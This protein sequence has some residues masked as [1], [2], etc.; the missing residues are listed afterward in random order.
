M[1]FLFSVGQWSV[2]HSHWG[3]NFW[4][5]KAG[6]PRGRQGP[7][8]ETNDPRRL[9]DQNVSLSGAL[10]SPDNLLQASPLALDLSFYMLAGHL[11]PTCQPAGLYSLPLFPDPGGEDGEQPRDR[12][13][14][15]SLVH[16]QPQFLLEL[17][18]RC[19]STCP[20]ACAHLG[21]PGTTYHLCLHA[22][23]AK[24]CIYILKW[25][26]TKEEYF[27]TYKWLN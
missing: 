12:A 2:G 16:S 3:R 25:L 5:E 19:S 4:K 15:P 23:P 6:V 13:S 14:I 24:E 1:F 8:E 11:D 10:L 18:T 26:K 7:L 21:N 22:L 20:L 27:M 9:A 17:P